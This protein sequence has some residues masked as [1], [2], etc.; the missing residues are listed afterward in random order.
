MG[1]NLWQ[2]SSFTKRLCIVEF[3]TYP[4]R[5]VQNL[6]KQ[7]VMVV[8]HTL[9]CES[10]PT[11]LIFW[12]L[13][14]TVFEMLGNIWTSQSLKCRASEWLKAKCYFLTYT[15]ILPRLGRNTLLLIWEYE[16]ESRKLADCR[17]HLHFNPRCRQSRRVSKSLLL[18]STVRRHGAEFILW[19]A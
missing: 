5:I 7:I 13:S 2:D 18:G 6:L 12:L 16:S 11:Y 1:A 17:N 15:D 10:L 3:K 4:Q 14:L 19:R 9:R 8:S